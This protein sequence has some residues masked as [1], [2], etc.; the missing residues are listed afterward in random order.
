MPVTR[1]YVR[2]EVARSGGGDSAANSAL[3]LG[4]SENLSD[5]DS[6]ATARTNLGLDA[7]LAA[8]APLASP[9]FTGT[10]TATGPLAVAGSSNV[11]NHA[12][13]AMLAWNMPWW[14]ATTSTILPTAGLV[15][16]TKVP[17]PRAMTI[18]NVEFFLATAGSS[19]TSGQNF[20][21]LY[22]SA[23]TLLSATADQT[24]AWQSSGRKTMALTAAQAVAAGHVYVAFFANGSTLPT[25]SRI[26]SSAIINAGLSADNAHFAT[27]DTGRTTSMP[28]SLGAFTA[29]STGYV[30]GVS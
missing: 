14:A 9:T 6:A 25:P 18:T 17:I 29:L 10:V 20:A 1:R 7:L 19:L 13:Y 23:K 21:A 22:S 26:A 8:K 16:V 28:S 30:V 24:T 11:L 27:A 3:F 2:R 5:L 4:E 15:H 12:D